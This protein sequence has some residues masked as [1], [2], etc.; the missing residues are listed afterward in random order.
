MVK[1]E[2]AATKTLILSTFL[3]YLN[4]QGLFLFVQGIAYTCAEFWACLLLTVAAI[5]P[6]STGFH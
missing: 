5:F 1:L 6:I 4:Y 2:S 3:F